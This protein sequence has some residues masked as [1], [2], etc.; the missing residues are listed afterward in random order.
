MTEMEK[1]ARL[2]DYFRVWRYLTGF[3][4]VDAEG[5]AE[6]RRVAGEYAAAGYPGDIVGFILRKSNLTSTASEE[7]KK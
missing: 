4:L 3:G 7:V 6:F 2:R 1:D 5:G